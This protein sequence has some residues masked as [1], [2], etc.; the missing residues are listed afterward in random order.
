MSEELERKW[1]NIYRDAK[2]GALRPVAVLADNLHLLPPAGRALEL[3]CGLGA[4]ATALARAGLAVQA[5]DISRVAVDKLNRLAREQKLGLVA[6]ARDVLARPPAPESFDVIVVSHYLE[7]A[8]ANPLMAALRPGGLLFYQTFVREVTDDYSGPSNPDFRLERG[9]LLRL[10]APL[11][12]LVYREEALV[13]DTRR[14]LRNE[15]QLVA[16]KA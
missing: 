15:A 2:P 12:P 3:A 5:W 6:E 8:L 10:F 4:N 14:G 11:V 13:G 7:R 16:Q 9:E 1:D